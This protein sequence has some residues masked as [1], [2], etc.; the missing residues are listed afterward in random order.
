[1]DDG[2]LIL[3]RLDRVLSGDFIYEVGDLM[4]AGCGISLGAWITPFPWLS[5]VRL[6]EDTRPL[7][8]LLH[9]FLLC[10]R[11]DTRLMIVRICNLVLGSAITFTPSSILTFSSSYPRPPFIDQFYYYFFSFT[12]LLKIIYGYKVYCRQRK[13]RNRGVWKDNNII[14]KWRTVY[15]THMFSGAWEGPFVSL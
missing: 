10:Y 6:V 7:K 5:N 15:L 1:M 4:A 8:R 2:A 3:V 14:C 12:Y 13:C 9:S 11:T